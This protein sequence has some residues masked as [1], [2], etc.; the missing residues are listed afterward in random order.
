MEAAMPSCQLG[1]REVRYC[2]FDCFGLVAGDQGRGCEVAGQ[3]DFCR[4]ADQRD[5]L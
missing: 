1:Q 2:G 4:A 3:G 5:A